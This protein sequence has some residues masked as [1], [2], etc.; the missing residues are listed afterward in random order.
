MDQKSIETLIN[1]LESDYGMR[2]QRSIREAILKGATDQE[3][4]NLIST[5]AKE[6]GLEPAQPPKPLPPIT[7]EDIHLL[8]WIA[9]N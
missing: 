6:I 9:I 4:S 7:Q 1:S 5:V 3:R 2:I 8:C